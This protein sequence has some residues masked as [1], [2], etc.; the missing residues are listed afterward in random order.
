MATST[1]LLAAIREVRFRLGPARASRKSSF[2]LEPDWSTGIEERMGHAP[3]WVIS[4]VVHAVILLLAMLL[5]V[6]LPP[7]QMDEVIITTDVVQREEPEYDEKEKR[8]L[9]RNPQE[10]KHETQMEHPVATHEQREVA[11]SF[12]IDNEMDTNTSRGHED[13]ISDIPLGGTGVSGSM[14]VGGGGMAGCFGYR[15]GGGRKRAI[16][17]FGG[18]PATESAVEAALQW[19]KRHQERGGYWDARKWKDNI[20]GSAF[21]EKSRHP[22]MDRVNVS[23]TGIALLAFLGAGYTAKAGKHK[24]TVAAAQ[25]WLLGVLDDRAGSGLKYGTFDTCN[26]T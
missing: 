23:M 15:D 21:R 3:W 8:D 16:E 20:D 2:E 24:D 26:Y 4:C 14:G 6:S 22:V 17:R 7:P 1:N 19:L 12:E 10:V 9:F 5:G 18:S 25:N 13:A 11:E